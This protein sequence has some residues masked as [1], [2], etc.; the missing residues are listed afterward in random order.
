V[1]QPAQEWFM[2]KNIAI[3]ADG[4]GN[5]VGKHDSN[6]LRL[7]RMADIRNR[8]RQLVIYDPGVGTWGAK[9][10][11]EQA[12]RRAD[13]P[14]RSDD[15]I[16]PFLPGR[17]AAW[18]LGLSFGYGTER[19]IKRL[20]CELA[21]QYEP[22]DH[23]YLFGFSR[24]AFT[25]RSL[26]G[27]IY[28]CGLVKS[29]HLDKIDQVYD[30][31][32]EHFE[33]AKN[34]ADLRSKKRVVDEF[35]RAHSHFCNIRFL[36]IF[37]TVKSVGY[38]RPKNLPHTRH[39]PIVQTVCHA[40][41]LDERRSF[42]APTTWGGLDADTRPAVY[43]SA[44]RDS[45]WYRPQDVK[46]VWFA[47]NHSDVGGGYPRQ[48][49]SPAD[50]SLRWMLEEARAQGLLI[51][52]AREAEVNGLARTITSGHRHD[53]LTRHGNCKD[54]AWKEVAWIFWRSVDHCP[55]R[56]LDN[57]PPPPRM[58]WR[59]RPSGRRDI[60]ASYRRGIVAV[61]ATAKDC[62]ERESCPWKDLNVMFIDTITYENPVQPAQ[63]RDCDDLL[64]SPGTQN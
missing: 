57:E 37:D 43:E 52:A 19:N 11:L 20:Y 32:R 17:L 48:C 39:N 18:L 26:A 28:R 54:V 21:R 31:Y 8:S 62:Y 59:F 23:V 63:R 53:E 3:F 7:C 13:G 64:R 12:F 56:D 9:L 40:L 33:Q 44:C 29:P 15:S 46:E 47:G 24:G 58:I 51:S 14:L 36:G 2:V 6:V 38:L 60:S 16:K 5:T 35:R 42:Y 4:T 1:R 61:H 41:S 34:S 10:E 22:G 45:G 30:L 25:V 49:S 50:V 55:R 27:L